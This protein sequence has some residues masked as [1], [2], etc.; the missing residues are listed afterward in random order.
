MANLPRALAEFIC[1]V[2]KSEP[3]VPMPESS[4]KAALHSLDCLNS[5]RSA[6]TDLLMAINGAERVGD[7]HI[8]GVPI[9]ILRGL[10]A[11]AVSVEVRNG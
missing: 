1:A 2:S 8:E 10:L 9:S 5:S 7:L 6:Q 3:G 11:N 4:L